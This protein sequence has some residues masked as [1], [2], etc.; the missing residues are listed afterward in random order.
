MTT[1]EISNVDKFLGT[2][3]KALFADIESNEDEDERAAAF[4]ATLLKHLGL[5]EEDAKPTKGK[6]TGKA[7]K[8]PAK[9]AAKGAKKPKVKKDPNAPKRAPSG[10]ILFGQERRPQLKD[11]DPNMTFGEL[12]K[13]IAAEWNEMSAKEKKPY[14]DKSAKAKVVADKKIAAYKAKKGSDD[15]ASDAESEE[16]PKAK[17]KAKAPI[18]K[19]PAKG[20]AKKEES[21]DEEES[22]EEKPKAK[23]KAKAPAKG[24][25]KAKKEESEDEE[26]EEDVEV[27]EEV[28]ESE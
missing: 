1:I 27:E 10:Y 6:G 3:C 13:A 18:K 28:E 21:E 5:D 24:K 17:G 15:E 9:P 12:T 16:K 23:G 11:E 4:R 22:E 19:A 14:N 2:V 20:K 26:V 7:K 25:A 8:A